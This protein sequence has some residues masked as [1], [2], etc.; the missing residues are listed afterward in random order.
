LLDDRTETLDEKDLVDPVV[1]EQGSAPR[2]VTQ[3]EKWKGQ[4][5]KVVFC[6]SSNLEEACH[7]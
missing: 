7:G 4:I 5:E 2:K 1:N 6:N 3:P